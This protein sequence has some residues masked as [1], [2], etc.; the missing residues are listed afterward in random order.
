MN[1]DGILV[2]AEPSSLKMKGYE[3]V[4]IDLWIYADTWGVYLDEII[5]DINEIL[6]YSFNIL[7]EVVGCP[8]EFPI[9]M[10]TILDEPTF[11]LELPK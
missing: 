3:K 6:P 4:E 1:S 5:V 11:R 2:K 9:A 7:I 10:N 8:I